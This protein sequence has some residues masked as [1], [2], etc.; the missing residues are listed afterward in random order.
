MFAFDF[1]FAEEAGWGTRVSIASSG[2]T[3]LAMW[4]LF[5][6]GAYII[7]IIV[8]VLFVNIGVIGFILILILINDVNATATLILIIITL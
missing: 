7:L 2:T 5:S 3:I 6:T 4:R 8:V 1:V